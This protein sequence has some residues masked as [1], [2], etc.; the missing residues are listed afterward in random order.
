[1]FVCRDRVG[2]GGEA[3]CR[4]RTFPCRDRDM[5]RLWKQGRD[6]KILAHDRVQPWK[7]DPMSRRSSSMS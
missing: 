1:M 6:M 3:L 4:D 7:E 2:N 5:C